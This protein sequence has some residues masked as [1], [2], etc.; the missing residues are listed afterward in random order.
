MLRSTLSFSSKYVQRSQKSA[1]NSQPV[2]GGR[3][4]RLETSYTIRY[5]VESF[6]A[7]PSVIIENGKEKKHHLRPCIYVTVVQNKIKFAL[8]VDKLRHAVR[9][10][11][12][13]P[14]CKR[15]SRW[16]EGL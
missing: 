2:S 3:E 1:D 12:C 7:F 13:K 5:K 9:F 14:G 15:W 6:R 16:V 11:D 10:K 4:R 8:P